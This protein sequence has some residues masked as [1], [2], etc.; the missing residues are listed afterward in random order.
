MEFQ[1]FLVEL[2]N[3]DVCDNQRVIKKNNSLYLM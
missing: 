3:G 2:F 1:S